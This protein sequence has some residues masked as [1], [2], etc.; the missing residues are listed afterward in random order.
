MLKQFFINFPEPFIGFSLAMYM[1]LASPF[2]TLIN[3]P[4]PFI[5]FSLAVYMVLASRSNAKAIVF[6]N[7][8]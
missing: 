2:N 5:G 3:F 8:S 1:V 4:E 6:H 7:F